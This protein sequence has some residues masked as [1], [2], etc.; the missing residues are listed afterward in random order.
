VTVTLPASPANGR[1]IVV[2]DESG[3]ASQQNRAIT[4]IPASGSGLI[5]GAASV[6]LNIDNGALQFVYRNGWRII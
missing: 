1:I 3:Q 2:K 6:T 4:I 5:D